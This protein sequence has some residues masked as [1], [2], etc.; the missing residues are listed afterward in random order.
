MS[1]CG[2]AG[3]TDR[4]QFA[5]YCDPVPRDGAERITGET[6]REKGDK[7]MTPGRTRGANSARR[8]GR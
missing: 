8:E 5:M 6:K 7:L 1:R 2:C 3:E 4:S